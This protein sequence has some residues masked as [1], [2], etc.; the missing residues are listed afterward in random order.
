MPAS[1]TAS[2]VHTA[3]I[4]A[5]LGA[6]IAAPLAMPPTLNPWPATT[7]SLGTVSVVMMARAALVPAS[8]PPERAI[9]IGAISGIDRVDRERDPDESRLAHQDLLGR[10]AH[11]ARDGGAEPLRRGVAG[12]PGG[13][14]GVA[15]G[16]DDSRRR[17]RASPPGGRGSPG[18]APPPPDCS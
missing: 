4:V 14:V 10:A 15:R 18:P 11:V 3:S 8:V 1:T 6:S 17:D 16:E 12:G 7:T 13:R 2:V 9:T 5:M